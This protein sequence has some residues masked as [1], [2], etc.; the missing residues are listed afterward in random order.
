MNLNLTKIMFMNLLMFSTLM[1]I[2]SSNWLSMWMGLELNLFSMIPIFNLKKSIYSIESTMKYFLIQAF[3][4]ILLLTFL[5]N[6]SLFF[7]INNNFLIIMPLLMKLSLMPFHLWLPSMVEGLNWMSCL[8]LM[9]WQKISPMIMISYLNTNKNMIFLIILIFINSIFGMNQNSV[10]KILAISSINN[11]S[12]MLFAILMNEALWV[13]YFIIYSI[14]NMIIIKMLNKFNINYINQMKFFNINFFM[15][16]NLFML[17]LSI[18]GLPPML[19]F[20]MK[21]MLIKTLIYNK[22]FLIMMMLIISTIMNLYMYMKMMYFTLFNFNLINKWFMQMKNNYN[23]N[24]LM[25]MNFFSIFF[26]YLIMY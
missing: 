6:K 11:S 19:G 3:A 1:T 12:W 23:Y 9:T 22:M 10:R 17:I 21:W 13:N 14:L 26:S 20:I 5:I 2:S 24:Y 16:I 8:L 4:S 15:K 25:F 7:M 18:M